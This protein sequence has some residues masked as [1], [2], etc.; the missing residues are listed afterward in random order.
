MSTAT[1][2]PVYRLTRRG[3]IVVFLLAVLLLAAAALA[4]AGGSV[5]TSEAEATETVV[6][7]P[8]DTLWSIASD[9]VSDQGGR[10]VRDTVDHLVQLNDLDTKVLAA[11]Q[12]LEVPAA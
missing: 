9:V 12:H 6:V 1:H 4:L 2:V 5:A 11:G 7:L 3:R 10:D 8:G